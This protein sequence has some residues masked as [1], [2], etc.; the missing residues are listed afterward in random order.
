MKPPVIIIII[1]TVEMFSVY[2]IKQN[3]PDFRKAHDIAMHLPRG[4]EIGQ[5][6][7]TTILYISVDNITM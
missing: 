3:P 1:I 6:Y 4:W 7:H 2:Y 5:K